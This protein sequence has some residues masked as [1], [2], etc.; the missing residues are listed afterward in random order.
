MLLVSHLYKWNN[1]SLLSLVDL[2]LTLLYSYWP[3]KMWLCF[4]SEELVWWLY[5][6]I[7]HQSTLVFVRL[8]M[9]FYLAAGVSHFVRLQMYIQMW[10][11]KVGL[12]ACLL[13]N[14][15]SPAADTLYCDFVRL[16]WDMNRELLCGFCYSLLDSL[17]VAL[18]Y[19]CCLGYGYI[20]CWCLRESV[21]C[22]YLF[23]LDNLESASEVF[24]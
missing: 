18:I 15:P 24:V 12:I 2:F 7:W 1:I 16:S 10:F 20:T 8:Q 19:L 4:V 14:T 9:W 3:L 5:L 22:Q 13:L 11:H 21:F 6:R 17:L 23:I